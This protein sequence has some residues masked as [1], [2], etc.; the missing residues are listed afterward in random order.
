MTDF[1]SSLAGMEQLSDLADMKLEREEG[2]EGRTAGVWKE[3][4]KSDGRKWY[5]STFVGLRLLTRVLTDRV[6]TAYMHL[7]PVTHTGTT[8]QRQRR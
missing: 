4:V 7:L 8:T 6:P 2:K 5:A 1:R 3:Y